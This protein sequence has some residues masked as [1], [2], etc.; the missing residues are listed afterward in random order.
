MRTLKSLVL[1]LFI[2][3]MTR[4]TIVHGQAFISQEAMKSFLNYPQV[5]AVDLPEVYYNFFVMYN[6]RGNNVMARNTFFKVL[7]DG[8]L[9]LGK[10]RSM[11]V[12]LLNRKLLRDLSIGDSLVVPTEFDIDFRAYSPFPTNYPGAKEFDKLFVIDKTIQAFAAYEY[13]TLMRWGIV[14]TGSEESRTPNGR[15]NYNW[16]SEYRVS[17]LSPPGEPWEMYW[18]FNFHLDRGI[19]THQYAMPSGGPTSHGCVRMVD[20]DAEFIYNWAESWTTSKRGV[21][22]STNYGKVIKPGT[23]VIVV[24][25]D[26]APGDAPQP[27]RYEKRYPILERVILPAH[28]YDVPAGT[29]QQEYFDNLRGTSE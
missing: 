24:G 29:E 11:L 7:G 5:E 23:T 4:P 9:K 2:L 14:N 19:H 8:D 15:F 18:V 3:L 26:P 12:E 20:A 21:G 27:F 10:Q 28:P 1:L 6:S 22:F 25:E 16:K 13:G 17:S